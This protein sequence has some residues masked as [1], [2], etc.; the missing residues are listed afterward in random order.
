[1]IEKHRVLGFKAAQ[2]CC[3]FIAIN[4]AIF[5]FLGIENI[6]GATQNFVQ[7]VNGVAGLMYFASFWYFS[8]AKGNTGYWGLFL[9]ILGFLGMLILYLGSDKHKNQVD[10]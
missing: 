7:I 5:T 8:K 6:K 9:A 4:V 1:M 3:L 10:H 2:L